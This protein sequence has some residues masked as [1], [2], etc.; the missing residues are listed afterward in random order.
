MT[1]PRKYGRPARFTSA[2]APC[3][4]LFE[5]TEKL[6]PQVFTALADK[7]LARFREWEKSQTLGTERALEDAE[8]ALEDA[9]REWQSRWRLPAEW[10]AE[11]A[12][13]LLESW[14]D[15]TV[16]VGTVDLGTYSVRAWADDRS[17]F[18]IEGE[19]VT[20]S[21]PKDPKKREQWRDHKR[22]LESRGRT[23]EGR[24]LRLTPGQV[25]E[26]RLAWHPEDGETRAEARARL[27][28]WAGARVEEYLDRV[29]TAA[30]AAGLEDRRELLKHAE[31]LV[32]HRLGGETLEAIA[33]TDN[34]DRRNVARAIAA[35]AR[36]AGLPGDV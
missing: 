20:A 10:C 28:A 8:R 13:E 6:A 22:W 16:P 32:R 9:I 1:K 21:E 12:L 19:T 15:G 35:F 25:W 3:R 4:A 7:P 29:E 26:Q 2:D 36:S 14:A 31:W 33:E 34:A 27:L 23:V 18:E 11:K 5:A 24:T 17:P 30:R